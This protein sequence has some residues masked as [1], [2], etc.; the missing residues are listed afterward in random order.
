MKMIQCGCWPNRL[1]ADEIGQ[2]N[3]RVA[4]RF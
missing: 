1:L 2:R 4:A 3:P